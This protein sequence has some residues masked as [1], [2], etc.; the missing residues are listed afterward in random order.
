MQAALQE[1]GSAPEQIDYVATHGTGTREGDA[2]EAAALRAVFNGSGD[3]VAA[4]SVKGAT[5]HLMAGAGALNAAVAALAICHQVV[6]A[7]ANLEEPDPALQG[8]WVSGQARTAG[9][10]QA[11]ALAQGMEGQ[12]VALAMRRVQ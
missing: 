12:S 10:E 6:P 8:D 3:G 5:G 1:A 7:T 2:S 4:S 11:L 9:V